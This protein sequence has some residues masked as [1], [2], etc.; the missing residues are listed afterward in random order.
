MQQNL[1]NAGTRLALVS[2]QFSISRQRIREDT[3]IIV[4]RDNERLQVILGTGKDSGD[5]IG[6]LSDRQPSGMVCKL[7]PNG[8]NEPDVMGLSTC[9]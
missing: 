2:T 8:K 1:E 9:R 7:C 4:I 3:M 6:A 5:G